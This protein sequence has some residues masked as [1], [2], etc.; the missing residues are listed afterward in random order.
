[1]AS[2]W[3]QDQLGHATVTNP[4]AHTSALPQ[5]DAF[6]AHYQVKVVL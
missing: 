5:E 2:V 6:L 4:A 1:M 3:V